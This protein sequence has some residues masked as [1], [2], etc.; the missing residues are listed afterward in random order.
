[1]Q[2]N[3]SVDASRIGRASPVDRLRKCATRAARPANRKTRSSAWSK[4]SAIA[5]GAS[6]GH[7]CTEGLS[8]PN[9]SADIEAL[10][11]LAFLYGSLE[12]RKG[13]V[14]LPGAPGKSICG[15]AVLRSLVS[16]GW[17]EV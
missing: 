17:L 4:R 16:R 7:C 2:N 14:F 10:L 11:R 6:S 12:E 9:R 13:K 3:R 15:E 1:M 5:V 8:M